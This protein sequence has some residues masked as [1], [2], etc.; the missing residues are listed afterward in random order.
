MTAAQ[1]EAE[2]IDWAGG[3]CPVPGETEVDVQHADGTFSLGVL[4]GDARDDD[5]RCGFDWWAH[6]DSQKGNGHGFIIAYRVV[7]SQ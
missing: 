5:P 2:W 7:V 6:I 4:A 3:E 1:T